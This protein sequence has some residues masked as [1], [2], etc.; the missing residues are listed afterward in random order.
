MGILD[1]FRKKDNC[2]NCMDD[3]RIREILIE[4]Y[5]NYGF[6]DMEYDVILDKLKY[7]CGLKGFEITD[8]SFIVNGQ[9][10]IVFS[11]N[12]SI[13]KICNNFYGTETLGE[14]VS[15]C[16]SILR[17]NIEECLIIKDRFFSFMEFPKLNTSKINN[18]DVVKMSCFL[19]DKGYLWHDPKPSNL[20][21]D[22]NGKLYLL[23]YGQ[24]IYIRNL[25]EYCKQVELNTYKNK[26]PEFDE[27]YNNVDKLDSYFSGRR[28]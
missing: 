27:I 28:R 26:F 20:G 13:I 11:C 17:P 6:S 3:D 23:D 14:Y 12:D 16:G 9:D 10:S 1:F 2:R 19:R 18:S 8:L 22:E 4:R 25:D 21:K 15:N 24:L 5:S 7:I